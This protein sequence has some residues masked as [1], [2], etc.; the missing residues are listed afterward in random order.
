MGV[1]SSLLTL[2]RSRHVTRL[3][4]PAEI[5]KTG[6]QHVISA[7]RV[8]TFVPA[9]HLRDSVAGFQEPEEVAAQAA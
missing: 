4:V 9:P 7:R 6:Q 8:V 5:R 2:V 3:R 1:M